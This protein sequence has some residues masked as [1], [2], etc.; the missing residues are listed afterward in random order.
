ML[1]LVV[2]VLDY[3]ARDAAQTLV[4][5]TAAARVYGKGG[6][7][8]YFFGNKGTRLAGHERKRTIKGTNHKNHEGKHQDI[9][10][11]NDT[12]TKR[13]QS[14][15]RNERYSHERKRDS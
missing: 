8:A 12:V 6:F 3:R 5:R 7:L 13:S 9:K 1:L 2:V 15:E 14:H 4:V 11:M 10:G